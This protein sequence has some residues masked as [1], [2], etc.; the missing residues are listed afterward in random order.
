MVL[1]CWAQNPRQVGD[2]WNPSRSR[3][4]SFSGAGAVS[5]E[6]CKY[7]RTCLVFLIAVE[8]SNPKRKALKLN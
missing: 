1:R 5:W 2:I 7:D 8:D 3:H 6:A 4:K